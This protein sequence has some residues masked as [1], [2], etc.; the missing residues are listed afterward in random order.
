MNFGLDYDGV[1][2]GPGLTIWA[3]WAKFVRDHG[4]K[5]Y[6]VTMRYP[7]ECHDILELLTQNLEGVYPTSRM[8]KKPHM[9]SL[10][11][12][13]DVWIDDHP[14]AIH[15]NAV[16]IWAVPTPEGDPVVPSYD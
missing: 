10:G 5:V 6:L 11:I 3:S 1:C 2:T 4:H 12:K 14:E 15:K 16:E 7:S 13:I 8:A 9:D